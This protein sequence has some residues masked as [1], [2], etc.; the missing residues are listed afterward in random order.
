MPIW[1]LKSTK[2]I[3]KR[4]LPKNVKNHPFPTHLILTPDVIKST[5]KAISDILFLGG[6]L[7]LDFQFINFILRNKGLTYEYNSHF[8][9]ELQSKF[10]EK[11]DKHKTVKDI[12]KQS[13]TVNQERFMQIKRE[14][15]GK[16]IH[17]NDK[18]HMLSEDLFSISKLTVSK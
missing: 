14:P 11:L 7:D 3:Q 5:V 4:A 9:Q 1:V 12:W 17:P 18:Y 6:V 2:Y 15:K 13:W 10:T 8:V 16:K